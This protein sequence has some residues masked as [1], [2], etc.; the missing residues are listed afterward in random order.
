MSSYEEI[1]R[2][3]S[4]QLGDEY[5]RAAH[6]LLYAEWPGALFEKYP[7]K[8]AIMVSLLSVLYCDCTIHYMYCDY[9]YCDMYC[10]LHVL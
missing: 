6:V 5:I 10:T 8:Y 2:E 9:M 4:L 3:V 1:S 7:F